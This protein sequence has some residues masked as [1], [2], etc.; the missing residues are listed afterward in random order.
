VTSKIVIEK[1]L[2][3]PQLADLRFTKPQAGGQPKVQEAR[4]VGGSL[5]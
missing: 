1:V 5:P 3:N 2:L 4:R